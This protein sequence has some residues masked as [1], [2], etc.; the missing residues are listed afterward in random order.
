MT[1][2]TAILKNQILKFLIL[3]IASRIITIEV[4]LIG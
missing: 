4:N 1:K 2:I 3:D